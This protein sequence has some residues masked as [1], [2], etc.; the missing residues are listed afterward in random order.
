MEP[1]SY[2]ESNTQ[3]LQAKLALK[4]KYRK[5]PV[6]CNFVLCI[7]SLETLSDAHVIQVELVSSLLVSKLTRDSFSA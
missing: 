5:V 1:G 7:L 2:S 3:V 4:T 6:M